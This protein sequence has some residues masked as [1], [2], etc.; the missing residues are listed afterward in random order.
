MTN[1]LSKV[2]ISLLFGLKGI[3]VV[4]ANQGKHQLTIRVQKD[5]AFGVCDHCG[6]ISQKVNDRHIH[7][8]TD[9]P[10]EVPGV[11]LEVVKR[12]W[13]CLNSFCPA[14][15]FTEQ[16]EGLGRKR[17]HTDLFCRRVYELSRRMTFSGVHQYL[18]EVYGCHTALSTIYRAAIGRLHQEVTVPESVD[19]PFVGLDEFSKGKGHDYGVVLVDLARR[20]VIDVD[21]G[22]KRKKA[23]VRLLEKLDGERLKACAI[24]M[25]PP[26]KAACGQAVPHALVV[27]DH[28]HVIKAINEGVD[29]VR[30]RVRGRLRSAQ[31]KR[32]LFQYK[33]L[34][35]TGLETLAASQEH[36][37]WEMLSWDEGLCHAYELKELLRAIYIGQNPHRAAVELDNWIEEAKGSGIPEV[38]DVAK[39]IARWKPEILNFWTYRISNAVTEG[40]IN[41]IQALRRRAYNYNNFQSLRLKILEQ[42]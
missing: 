23:A 13:K 24:D 8:V 16:I 36:R 30:K 35:L 1:L 2:E 20:K 15:T 37:L 5:L 26:F 12:R 21:G 27:V 7:R 39:T 19:T 42:E 33:E 31:K 29:K 22:G 41:K 25:W 4:A 34:L 18:Q 14:K 10:L 9:R 32:A 40:K 11:K 6:T 28:F 3:D 38:E 17:T